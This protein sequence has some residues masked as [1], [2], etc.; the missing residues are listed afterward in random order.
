[1]NLLTLQNITKTYGEKILFEGLNFFINKGDKIA[2]VAKNGSGKTTLLRIIG[3][4]EGSDGDTSK[5]IV[6]RGI[7]IGFLDQEPDLPLDKTVLEAVC[8]ADNDSLRAVKAYE[9]SM[10][11]NDADA[12]QKAMERMEELQAWDYENQVKQIMSQLNITNYDKKIGTLSGG[13]KKRAALAKVLIESPDLL[14]LDEPTNHLDLDMIEWLERFFKEKEITLFLVTHDRYF[15]DGVCNQILELD[16]GKLQKYAGTYGDYLNTKAEQQE[17][18]ARTLDKTKK[19]YS[20]ELEWMRRQPKARGTKAKARVDHFYDVKEKSSKK[21]DDGKV[22]LEIQGQ[23]LGK[24]IVEFHNIEKSYGNKKILDKFNYKFQKGEKLGIIGVNGAGKSTFLKILA[25][26]EEPDNGRIIHGETVSIGHYK[27]DG[28]T[29]TEDQRVIDVVKDVAN[30]IPLN[31]GKMITAAQLCERFLFNKEQQYVYVSKLSG[32]ERKRLYL[33]TILMK[34]PNFL[35]LDEPTNDLDIMTLNVLEEF[36]DDYQGCLVVVTHDRY[37][38]DR[39][40]DHLFVFRG[41]G[42]VEDF[43]GNYTDFRET[44]TNLQN[45]H[46]AGEAPV[47]KNVASTPVPE[48]NNTVSQTTTSTVNNLSHDEQKELKRLEKQIEK[49]EEERKKLNEQFLVISDANQITELS[50]KIAALA[51]DIETKE[52]RWLELVDKKG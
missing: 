28:L 11:G 32:G 39:L 46:K 27:Q 36:L 49:L 43:N 13:Q 20:R 1:M 25:L 52:F 34:N 48:N 18:E 22:E 40:V 4:K 2:L 12:Q 30:F 9:L 35:I 3:G 14:V 45:T 17:I 44:Y 38:M 29:I 23:R 50:K 51:E 41:E 47:Q 8:E 31:K 21:L 24:K 5:V 16:G 10:L 37:F 6:T 26:E 42:A 33:L 19:L 15:L 7:K